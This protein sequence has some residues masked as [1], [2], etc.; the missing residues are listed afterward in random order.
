MA[1]ERVR[2]TTVYEIRWDENAGLE[3]V[4]LKIPLR[5]GGVSQSNF[6]RLLLRLSVPTE[7]SQ[8]FLF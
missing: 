6:G 4:T 7:F 1:A 2:A 5:G 8:S 3:A